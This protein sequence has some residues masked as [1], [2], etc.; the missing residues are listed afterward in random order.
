MDGEQARTC[1][2]FKHDIGA[3]D[4]GSDGGN[5]PKPDRRAELLE[6]LGGLRAPRVGWKQQADLAHHRQQR[7]RIVEPLGQRRAEFAQE[8]DLRNF[9][10]VISGLPVPMP[11]GVGTAKGRFHRGAQD[12][13]VDG[14]AL[15]DRGKQ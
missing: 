3:G 10:G 13:G 14:L 5:E 6:A 9:A 4:G 12:A 7:C 2:R 8:Q 11:V 1:R 15:F